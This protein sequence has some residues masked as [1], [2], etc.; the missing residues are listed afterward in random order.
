MD[1]KQGHVLALT[2]VMLVMTSLLIM[3]AYGLFIK[4]YTTSANNYQKRLDLL[5]LEVIAQDLYVES[6]KQDL[7]Q[8][9]FE[10]THEG[11]VYEIKYVNGNY[12]IEFNKVFDNYVG[13]MY[14]S[15]NEEYQ[16]QTWK[17]WS[18]IGDGNSTLN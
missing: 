4:H 15:F 10:L 16:I 9:N 11:V 5:S 1:K 13:Y 12:I 7:V 14:A 3:V 8:V 2:T 6:T 18:V 17:V